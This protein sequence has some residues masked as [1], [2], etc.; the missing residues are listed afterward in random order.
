MLRKG[1]VARYCPVPNPPVAGEVAPPSEALSL[2]SLFKESYSTRA[3]KE[4]N[5]IRPS[6]ELFSTRF[7]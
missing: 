7:V 2:E 5:W 1:Q 4:Y 6:S 3:A